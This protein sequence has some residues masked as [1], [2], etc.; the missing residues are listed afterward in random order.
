MYIFKSVYAATPLI[1]SL[2]HT[3]LHLWP[4]VYPKTTI[5]GPVFG[6]YFLILHA[7]GGPMMQGPVNMPMETSQIDE[8]TNEYA[9]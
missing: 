6:Q 9:D 3:F 7:K 2:V 4:M 5:I 8:Y 1:M